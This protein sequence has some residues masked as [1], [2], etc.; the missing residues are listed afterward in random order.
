MKELYESEVLDEIFEA[1][2]DNFAQIFKEKEPSEIKRAN[3]LYDRT[4]DKIEN[5]LNNKKEKE[6]F[7][8]L[9]EQ[10]DNS[11]LDKMSYWLRE[12]YKLGFCDAY[13]LRI[14]IKRENSNLD[15]KEDILSLDYDSF[16]E[17]FEIYKTN[18]LYKSTEYKNIDN[19]LRQ[20]KL[21]YP[22]VREF[23]EDGKIG[24]FT[25]NEQEAILEVRKLEGDIE[26][27]EKK[28]AF[29][30]GMSEGNIV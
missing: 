12:Y 28:E 11:W 5:K 27:L 14:E 20:I 22:K 9:I 8:D 1:R 23:I 4:L 26:M 2:R 19:K 30:L 24:K 13:N 16:F 10:L 15:I 17:L 7:M 3:L 25:P 21:K 6:E 18:R 29:R